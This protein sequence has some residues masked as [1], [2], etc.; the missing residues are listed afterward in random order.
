M[1]ADISLPVVSRECGEAGFEVRV[2]SY[3]TETQALQNSLQLQ[4]L[5]PEN[6]KRQHPE[7]GE[8]DAPPPSPTPEDQLQENSGDLHTRRVHK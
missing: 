3:E 8:K 6:P 5:E 2:R 7:Q 4:S 1:A